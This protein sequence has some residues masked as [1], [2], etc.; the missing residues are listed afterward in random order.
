VDI[1]Q[2]H[3]LWD[4]GMSENMVTA[5]DPRLP[6]SEGLDE[7]NHLRESDV[8]RPRQN[9]LQCLAR[10]QLSVESKQQDVRRQGEATICVHN[11]FLLDKP[12][13]SS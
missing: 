2:V 5:T 11:A 7:I 3:K 12:R 10:T 8:L 4:A 6:K 9:L 13:V 1:L